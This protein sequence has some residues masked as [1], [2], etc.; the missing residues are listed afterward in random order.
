MEPPPVAGKPSPDARRSR[1]CRCRRH[2]SAFLSRRRR[3]VDHP[4]SRRP[5]RTGGRWPARSSDGSQTG[6]NIA[7]SG[8]QIV[9]PEGLGQRP[10][11]LIEEAFLEHPGPAR[12]ID[13]RMPGADP[14]HLR[15]DGEAVDGPPRSISVTSTEQ[16]WPGSVMIAMA[17]TG[18]DTLRTRHPWVSRRHARLSLTRSLSSTTRMS[19]AIALSAY[20]SAR[21]RTYA[22]A[23]KMYHYFCYMASGGRKACD[24]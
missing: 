4:R 9:C 22:R 7:D 17:S 8:E 2:H 16:A 11:R 6:G 24:H 20:P 1:S 23:T 18:P 15:G 19:Q 12:D 21:N 3:G 10:F 14:A 13:D 5:S